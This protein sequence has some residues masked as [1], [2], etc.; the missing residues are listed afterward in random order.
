[1]LLV[2]DKSRPA[3]INT[4]NL[5]QAAA[6]DFVYCSKLRITLGR[7]TIRDI[8]KKVR[9]NLSL[10]SSQSPFVLPTACVYHYFAFSVR[11]KGNNA[12]L[13]VSRVMPEMLKH[14]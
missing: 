9:K 12:H 14:E 1:M 5:A 13:S 11:E 8:Q 3:C 7:D 2:K 10:S 6:I 4:K